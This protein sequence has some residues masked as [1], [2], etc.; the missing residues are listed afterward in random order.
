MFLCVMRLF[1]I[2]D[3]G[4]VMV[5]VWFIL[6]DFFSWLIFDFGICRDVRCFLVVLISVVLLCFSVKSNFFCVLIRVGE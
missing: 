3:C 4:V 2:F 1:S 5:M 6:L